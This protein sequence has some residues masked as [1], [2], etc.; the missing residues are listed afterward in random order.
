MEAIRRGIKWFVLVIKDFV[1][2]SLR[3]IDW[4]QLYRSATTGI[5]HLV[6]PTGG[7][8]LSHAGVTQ[9]QLTLS[10][11]NAVANSNASSSPSSPGGS[12]GRHR[13]KSTVAP[14]SRREQQR[15]M[16]E[17]QISVERGLDRE[18]EHDQDHD[19]QQDEVDLVDVSIRGE[20]TTDAQGHALHNG[21]GGP[22]HFAQPQLPAP[23]P[24]APVNNPLELQQNGV[25][26]VLV[27]GALVMAAASLL[28]LG[29]LVSRH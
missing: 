19:H 4:F 11:T 12:E 25:R 14:L 20:R 22:P 9:P 8:G 6:D 3:S 24:Q 10:I 1:L 16:A 21:A 27:N 23:Q 13:S 7:S 5:Q 15:L 26:D 18:H 2:E 17:H 29:F 28:G